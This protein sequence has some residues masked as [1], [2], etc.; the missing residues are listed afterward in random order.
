MKVKGKRGDIHPESGKVFWKRDKKFKCGAW[1]VS[2]E[3]FK[4]LC[5]RQKETNESW[6]ASNSE[7]HRD[8]CT[9]WYHINK[10]RVRKY[11]S[12]PLVKAARRIRTN[13]NKA[14]KRGNF[15]DEIKSILGCSVDEFKKH[16]TSTFKP[17]MNWGNY[18]DWHIDHI[19]PFH[20]A[21]TELEV[22]SLAHFS[23]TQAL[24]ASENRKKHKSL[25]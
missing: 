4:E 12:S 25:Q 22:Y 3:K 20:S 6:Y 5:S 21:T 18:G 2:P 14:I 11:H 16:I 8:R 7:S 17:G 24:W 13:T 15:S 23:N 10:K 1:W 9:R 19:K